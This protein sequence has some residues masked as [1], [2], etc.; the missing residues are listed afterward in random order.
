MA[1]SA[2]PILEYST[3]NNH[4]LQHLI[5]EKYF[6]SSKLASQKLGNPRESTQNMTVELLTLINSHHAIRLLQESKLR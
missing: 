2:G 4:I 1:L 5:A 3:Y 6:T